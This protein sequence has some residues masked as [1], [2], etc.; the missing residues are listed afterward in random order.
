MASELFIIVLAIS[1]AIAVVWLFRRFS[2]LV[3][4]AVTGLAV[5]FIVD[6]FG[7]T[8]MLGG[9]EIPINLATI[10]ICTFGGIPGAVILIILSL[11][12]IPF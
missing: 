10:L 6:Y 4:N 1:F 12:G 2:V 9:T 8:E 7:L 3:L 11:L 5:L